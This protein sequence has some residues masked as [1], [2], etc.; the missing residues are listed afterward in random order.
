M[1]IY[2]CV[3]GT[4]ECNVGAPEKGNGACAGVPGGCVSEGALFGTGSPG[5]GA[6]GHQEGLVVW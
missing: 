1:S 2:T 3:C 6:G 5:K 4:P